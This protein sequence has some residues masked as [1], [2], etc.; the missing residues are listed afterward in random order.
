MCS[1]KNGRAYAQTL[2]I[3]GNISAAGSPV[4]FAVVLFKD[5]NDTAVLFSSLTDSSGNYKVDI[6]T[7]VKSIHNGP[8]D[9]RLEQ[10]YPNPF[11]SSTYIS[12][13]INA[14]SMTAVTI[15]DVLG[16]TVRK[17]TE[18]REGSGVH[19]IVWDGRDNAG[20]IV[21]PGVYLYQLRVGGRS[22][23]RKMLFG[24]D[25]G[26][27]T[28]RLGLNTANRTSLPAGPLNLTD[29]QNSRYI[30]QVMGTDSTYPQILAKDFGTVTVNRDTSL[31]LL[32][33]KLVCP[34]GS[35]FPVDGATLAMYG[36]NG[37]LG[38][39]TGSHNGVGHGAYDFVPSQYCQAFHPLSAP[40]YI[41]INNHAALESVSSF[42]I[43]AL[44]KV[45]SITD[46][47]MGIL[48]QMGQGGSG[49]SFGFANVYGENILSFRLNGTLY[50]SD[51]Y[52][53]VISREVYVAVTVK[54]GMGNGEIVL[55]GGGAVQGKFVALAITPPVG[56][57]V[58]RIGMGNSIP[59]DQLFAEIDEIKFSGVARDSLQIASQY[60]K[61]VADSI[62][63]L[64]V[65][66]LAFV[67]HSVER[68]GTWQGATIN[69]KDL[70]MQTNLSNDTAAYLY[71]IDRNSFTV[72]SG[73]PIRLAKPIG[74][75]GSIKFDSDS[76]KLWVA[77]GASANLYRVDPRTGL[78]DG[79]VDFN[80]FFDPG[81]IINR[82]SSIA[83]WK[84]D[85]IAFPY[86]NANDLVQCYVF[87]NSK[88]HQLANT[89]SPAQVSDLVGTFFVYMGNTAS[90]NF[91]I[92]GAAVD[93][94][95]S[96]AIWIMYSSS[97]TKFS[98][99][100]KINVPSSILVGRAQVLE[101]RRIAK[102]GMEDIAID[103]SEN[104][105]SGNEN[106]NLIYEFSLR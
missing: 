17:F 24:F 3:D 84:D 67:T 18:R 106:D 91:G 68:V 20:R 71:D 35:F 65:Q 4:R 82:F 40:A 56:H 105:Y 92:Q 81:A 32:M 62:I 7:S 9:F 99:I 63:D 51:L 64:Q 79:Y 10:N 49:W 98:A 34:N 93:P 21:F 48:A 6:V 59:S 100:A 73:Y 13:S 53:P 94:S 57:S 29:A 16:R 43:E 1:G 2:K 76:S 88:L 83:L 45:D 60:N 44:L 97:T 46:G 95:D 70:W 103:A 75:G 58:F 42:T 11:T 12:Y 23:V 86:T 50:Q 38:D 19:G 27:G 5:A 52:L 74:H 30:L 37:N 66:P 101:Y 28:S 15:F 26:G 104:V 31:N 77:D 54:Y 61:L 25:A 80:N 85:L 96:N 33:D 39:I 55:Y 87:K 8:T 69:G 22:E 90:F 47:N 14:E 89:S 41:T 78:Y 72:D 102:P 36:F